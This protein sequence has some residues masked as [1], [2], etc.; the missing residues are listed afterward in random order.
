MSRKSVNGQ[1]VKYADILNNSGAWEVMGKTDTSFIT[2]LITETVNQKT[3]KA[4]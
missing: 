2:E 3:Y 1:Y 4:L